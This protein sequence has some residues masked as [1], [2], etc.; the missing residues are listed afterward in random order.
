VARIPGEVINMF[1]DEKYYVSGRA[2]RGILEEANSH[3]REMG[4]PKRK[5][6][7]WSRLFGW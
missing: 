2:N 1:V 5:R 7:F 4:Y 3:L 6:G